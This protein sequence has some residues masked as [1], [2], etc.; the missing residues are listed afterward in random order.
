MA[1]YLDTSSIHS[2]RSAS[3]DTAEEKFQ[4]AL[5]E[6]TMAVRSA[7]AVAKRGMSTA[8]KVRNFVASYLEEKLKDGSV[9]AREEEMAP[10]LRPSRGRRW[11]F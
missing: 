1:G 4:G 5:D 8:A 3:P 10:V 9:R 6:R 7:V 11:S 2:R